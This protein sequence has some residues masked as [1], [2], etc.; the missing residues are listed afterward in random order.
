V[1]LKPQ[2]FREIKRRLEAVGFVEANQRGSHVKFV[3]RS[4]EVLDTAIVPIPLDQ[5]VVLGVTADPVPHDSVLPHDGQSAIFKTDANRIDVVLAFQFLELQTRVFRIA[6]EE[7][8]GALGVQLST[9][10]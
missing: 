2:S 5:A 6:L 3:R 8:I 4:D 7:T 1:R 10:G 9:S